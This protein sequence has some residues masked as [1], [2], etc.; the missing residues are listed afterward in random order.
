MAQMESNYCSEYC[1]FHFDNHETGCRC[2]HPD[3]QSLRIMAFPEMTSFERYFA[4]E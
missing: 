2:G 1:E 4:E 3:C